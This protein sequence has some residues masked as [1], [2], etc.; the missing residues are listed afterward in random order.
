MRL[1][2]NGKLIERMTIKIK[3]FDTGRWEWKVRQ[4]Y[5]KKPRVKLE[6]F[7]NIL[8]EIKSEVLTHKGKEEKKQELEVKNEHKEPDSE[9]KTQPKKKKKNTT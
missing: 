4:K 3:M 2:K 7:L 8:D 9:T 1:S 6:D 5:E